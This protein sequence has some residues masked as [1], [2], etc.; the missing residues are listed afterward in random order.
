MFATV[1]GEI[2][3][4]REA[5]LGAK[6]LSEGP[7]QAAERQDPEQGVAKLAASLQIR[8]PVARIKIP[9]TDDESRAEELPPSGLFDGSLYSK[10]MPLGER[11][12]TPLFTFS[13]A[14]VHA[15][16]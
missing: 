14:G 9:N 16:T 2:L 11:D 10:S 4:C 6:I 5:Q 7:N 3:G 13:V 1:L 12:F 8:R 15:I